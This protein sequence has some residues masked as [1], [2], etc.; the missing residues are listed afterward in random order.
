VIR[1]HLSEYYR[2]WAFSII[3]ERTRHLDTPNTRNECSRSLSSVLDFLTVP[4]TRSKRSRSPSRV[5]DFLQL[6]RI[7]VPPPNIRNSRGRKPRTDK[8]L[9]SHRQ[10]R[11]AYNQT[12]ANSTSRRLTSPRDTPTAYHRA[13]PRYALRRR[14]PSRDRPAARYVTQTAWANHKDRAIV[15]IT[16]RASPMKDYTKRDK[17]LP[18]T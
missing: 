18:C 10:A 17:L 14:C 9:N 1:P 12:R 16:L 11:A 4:F 8:R 3:V 5:L 15:S 2:D 6:S 13:S 7:H